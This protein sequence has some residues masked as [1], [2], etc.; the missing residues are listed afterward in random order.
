MSDAEVIAAIRRAAHPLRSIAAD[1]DPL[2]DLVAD[3]SLALIGEATHGTAEF[4][5]SRAELTKRLIV[6]RGYAAVAVE[7]DWPDAYRVNRYVRH[8]GTDTSAEEALGDVRRF[9]MWMWRNTIVRDF[10]EWLRDHNASLEPRERVGFYGLDLYSMYASMEKVLEYLQRV[11]PEAAGRARQRYACFETYEQDPQ[12]YGY[13]ASFGFSGTCEEDVVQA[14]AELKRAA[15][16]YIIRDGWVEADEAF[17]AQQNARLVANAERY[18]RSM[19]AGRVNTWNLRDSHMA[20]TLDALR[21]HLGRRGREQKVA[22]WEH[23]SHLG[24]ARATSTSHRGEHNVG[25]LV[26]ERHGDD[27]VLIGFTTHTGTVS[28]ADDWDTPVQRKHIRPS[29]PGTWE[30]LLHD[31]AEAMEAKDFALVMRG[32]PALTEA[33]SD[34]RAER[35]IG[36]IYRPQSERASHLFDA[37]LSEQFDAVLHYDESHALEPLEREADWERGEEDAGVPELYPFGL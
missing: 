3:R 5:Q 15:R 25:Q 27:A 10:I 23:N 28:A 14:L 34:S 7:A 33:L 19:F 9:P 4:Y 26:R 13:A 37:T 21:G 18:Y 35:A 20:D 6:E 2:M 11:D 31:A 24:D 22:V 8:E 12:Q 36:V 16:S 17:Y 30:R 29:Q 32:D 1:L